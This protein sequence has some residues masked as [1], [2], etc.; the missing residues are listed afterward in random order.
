MDSCSGKHIFSGQF[1]TRQQRDI[2]S[3]KFFLRL[4]NYTFQLHCP[5][6]GA[7]FTAPNISPFTS[8]IL[9]YIRERI[10]QAREQKFLCLHQEHCHG[11]QCPNTSRILANIFS[12]THFSKQQSR[13]FIRSPNLFF[14]NNLC[15]SDQSEV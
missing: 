10:E 14:V 3:E 2:W 12:C 11:S 15:F 13:L 7:R 6:C 4:L 9:S 5:K 8:T 1:L